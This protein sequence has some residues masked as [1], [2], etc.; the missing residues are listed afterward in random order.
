VTHA[1]PNIPRAPLFA[2]FALVCS[3]LLPAVAAAESGELL[4]R[5]DE[6]VRAGDPLGGLELYRQAYEQDPD[7]RALG[8]L[9]L[10]EVTLRRWADAEKHLRA[11][12]EQP[13]DPWVRR[14]R[15]V[16]QPA[17]QTA[18]QHMAVLQLEGGLPGAVV[19]ID[20]ETVA[21][22]PLRRGLRLPAG[23]VTVEVTHPGY[24]PWR[25]MVSLDGGATITR[26]VEL[27][28]ADWEA[29]S[30][31]SSDAEVR[32][33]E[34][35]FGG[36]EK[37]EETTIHDWMPWVLVGVGGAAVVTSIFTG[38]S[39][40]GD[41]DDLQAACSGL[42][43]C[44]TR[45]RELRDDAETMALVTDVLW[46]SGSAL[47]VGGL[48]WYVA[49]HADDEEQRAALIPNCSPDGCSLSARGRF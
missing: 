49:T 28:E 8:S 39:A 37:E 43:P 16:L 40:S 1:A 7:P 4:D 38:L 15:H 11:A 48:V 9:G 3:V 33:A 13:D 36:P 34:Y 19:E 29:G 23:E 14:N 17:L 30:A 24:R 31:A 18:G 44:P 2:L 32:R 26:T 6:R 35:A 5:G 22:L 42:D 21:R 27:R 20:G 46:I 12:L 10:V 47:T 45:Y 41:A 25:Q